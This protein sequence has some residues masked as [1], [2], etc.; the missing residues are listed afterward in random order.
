VVNRLVAPY[1]SK[2]GMLTR[3]PPPPWRG[4]YAEVRP[5]TTMV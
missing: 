5:F 1:V 3:H 4:A 2:F